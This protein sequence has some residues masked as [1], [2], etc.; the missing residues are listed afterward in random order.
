M[1]S[2][3]DANVVLT[4]DQQGRVGREVAGWMAILTSDL[5]GFAYTWST[6]VDEI[7]R[8]ARSPRESPPTAGYSPADVL[9]AAWLVR[10]GAWFENR[11]T[12]A[13]YEHTLNDLLVASLDEKERH[14]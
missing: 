2:T 9:N 7:V 1:Q 13:N 10:L 6:T 4:S 14:D 5:S 11:P 8:Y 12:S 3:A